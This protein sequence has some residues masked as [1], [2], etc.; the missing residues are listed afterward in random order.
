[1]L[2]A[3]LFGYN[4]KYKVMKLKIMYTIEIYDEL[5]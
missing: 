2:K 5:L 3:G 1:M 4:K